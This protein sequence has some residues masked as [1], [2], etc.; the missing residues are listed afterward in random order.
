MSGIAFNTNG[1]KMYLVGTD[2][3]SVYQYSLSTPF[4]VSTTSYDSVTLNVSSQSVFPSAIEFNNDGTKMFIGS[5]NTNGVF[6]YSLSSGFDLST[7]S[8]DSV[9]FDPSSQESNVQGIQFNNDGTKMYIIGTANNTVFQYSLST[10]FNLSTASYDSVSFSVASQNTTAQGLEFNNDGTKLFVVDNE[11]TEEVY[12]YDLTTGF[13]ISTASY[14]NIKLDVSSQDSG[15]YGIS[16]NAD[17]SKMYLA[18]QDT[19]YI[20]QYSTAGS[21]LTSGQSYYVQT[22]GTLGTTAASPS[23]FAGTAVSATKLIVK[24]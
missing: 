4:N 11:P 6:Q 7:A 12:Q 22:D 18:G 17:G 19:D 1:T 16:F 21:S 10:G 15:T 23:V 8:Y 14:S 13:D 2:N 20:Y 24:G 3:D 5:S 9:S